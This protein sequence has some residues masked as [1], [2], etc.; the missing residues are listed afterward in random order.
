MAYINALANVGE[1]NRVKMNEEIP[2]SK[3]RLA[4]QIEAANNSIDY[5]G[6]NNYIFHH[7][8]VVV[9]IPISKDPVVATAPPPPS[10]NFV[11]SDC[12]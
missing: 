1:E 2:T 11:S 3:G 9:G 12:V 4:S 7:D 10:S 8:T 5:L 6:G